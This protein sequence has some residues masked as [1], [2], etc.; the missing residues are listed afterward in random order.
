MTRPI[1]KC[2]I[3]SG[4]D[5]LTL[6]ELRQAARRLTEEGYP[7]VIDDQDVWV[8]VLGWQA[9]IAQLSSRVSNAVFR[10]DAERA[11]RVRR[12]S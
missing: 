11:E 5:S 2:R 7:V 4:A 12:V 10:R 1:A 3:E 8:G 6:P 9:W